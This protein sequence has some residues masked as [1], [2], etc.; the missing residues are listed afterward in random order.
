VRPSHFKLPPPPPS[1]LLLL[2]L[3][4]G[5]RGAAFVYVTSDRIADARRRH[6][7]ETSQ[8]CVDRPRQPY[9]SRPIRRMQNICSPWISAPRPGSTSN[10]TVKLNRRSPPKP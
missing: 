2:L 5:R 7:T 6:I 3:L 4:T 9:T 1:L 8:D 10:V